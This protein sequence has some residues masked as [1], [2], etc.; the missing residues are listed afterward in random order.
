[1]VVRGGK[2]YLRR[3]TGTL[4]SGISGSVQPLRMPNTSAANHCRA[5]TG[6]SSRRAAMTGCIGCLIQHY[7]ERQ[8][9]SNDGIAEDSRLR[10]AGFRKGRRCSFPDVTS[11]QRWQW[12][13]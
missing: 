7:I 4:M 5:S 10:R 13:L 9:R 6:A 11:W 2:F 1:L 3:G 12:R 8:R